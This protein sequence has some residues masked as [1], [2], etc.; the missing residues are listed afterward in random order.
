MLTNIEKGQFL[1]LFNRNGYVLDFSTADFDAFTMA[2]VGRALCKYYLESK[3]K[4]LNA[5][6]NEASDKDCCKLLSDLFEYYELNF[7]REY[8]PDSIASSPQYSYGFK[9]DYAKL[10]RQCKNIINRESHYSSAVSESTAYLKNRFSSSYLNAQIDLLS[11]MRTENP[12]E[13]IGKSKELIESCCKTILEEQHISV[14]KYSDIN[15]LL[16]RTQKVLHISSENIEDSV[17]AGDIVKRL[18]GNLHGVAVG[19]AKLRNV[20][21]SGHGKS[22]SYKG[23]EIRHAKLAVGSSLTICEYLWETYEWRIREGPLV[24][25]AS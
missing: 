7:E 12:T 9:E 1:K 6:I 23:L 24:R 25:P 15:S 10:Y 11:K 8:K 13:A 16:R 18:F 20:Y 14:D 21:G 19:I 2:S 17:P 22:A 5:F 4:S 3:G